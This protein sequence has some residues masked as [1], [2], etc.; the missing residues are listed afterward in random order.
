MYNTNLQ[1]GQKM[2]PSLFEDFSVPSDQSA[3]RL[4]CSQWL[5]ASVKPHSC[6]FCTSCSA[7]QSKSVS[8]L[9]T[10]FGN[11][12]KE[13]GLVVDNLSSGKTTLSTS[14][15]EH[16]EKQV[17]IGPRFQAE[18]PEWTGMVSE[19]DSKWLGTRVWL[20]EYQE[21]DALVAMDPIGK[22][23][24][25]VCCCQLPGSVGCVRF[26]I[27]EE[28]MQLKLRLGSL[29]YHWRF[30]RMGEEVSLRWSAEEE[31]RFKDMIRF[32]PLSA[33]KCFW[34][35]A[36]KYFPRKTREDLVSYYFNVYLV[37]RRSYQNRVTPYDIDSDDDETE[38][39]SFSDGYG[40]EA[41]IVPGANMLICS[42]NMQCIDFT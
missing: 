17:A 26:H 5:P 28:R 19:S 6:S 37:G 10:E 29:F 20:S 8:P 16:V 25:T 7:P 15:E 21:H 31:K 23:R 14:G 27:A 1:N 22:G 42:Q 18:V 33:G 12:L 38:F 32:N 2:H 34:D 40:H 41:V 24:P 35:N 3:E 39:G 4:R 36:Y 9:K 30:D 11:G 13:Q